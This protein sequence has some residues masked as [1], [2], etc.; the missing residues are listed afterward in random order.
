MLPKAVIVSALSATPAFRTKACWASQHQPGFST[1]ALPDSHAH[2]GY[3]MTHVIH[4]MLTPVASGLFC[5]SLYC[6]LY[7]PILPAIQP[8]HSQVWLQIQDITKLFTC[9]QTAHTVLLSHRCTTL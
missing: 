3:A 1:P 8:V 6:L 9:L 2:S 5:T 4:S 7:L